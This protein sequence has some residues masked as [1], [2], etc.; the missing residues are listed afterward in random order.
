MRRQF[1]RWQQ[2][3]LHNLH[4]EW[5]RRDIAKAAGDT[6][7]WQWIDDVV[8]DSITDPSPT[9]MRDIADALAAGY[10]SSLHSTLKQIDL[11]DPNALL[12]RGHTEA[13]DYAASRGAE[14][15][16]KRYDT[17]GNLV[18]NPDADW[19]ITDTTRGVLRR[20][21]QLA[22]STHMDVDKLADHI[23]DTGVFSDDRAEMI[24]RTEMNMAQS[25]GVLEAGRQAA[26]EGL[27]VQ[28]VWTL[29]PNPCPLCEDAAAEG[30]I[31]LDD[32]FG[33]DAGDAPPL[34]PNCECSLDLFV[35]EE[36]EK[37]YDPSEP[38]DA[39]GR[40]TSGGGGGGE[41]ESPAEHYA[42]LGG[43]YPPHGAK[44]G[45]HDDGRFGVSR[46]AGSNVGKDVNLSLRRGHV[47]GEF[48]LDPEQE[49]IAK[50]LT[51]EINEAPR[52][53]EDV[54]VYRAAALPP[55]VLGQMVPGAIIEDKGFTSATLDPKVVEFHM[56]ETR[57]YAGQPVQLLEINLPKGSAAT[58][59]KGSTER[60][61][62]VQR[63]AKFKVGMATR[64]EGA[65][66][67]TWHLELMQ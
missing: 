59:V 33:S 25:Q 11:D 21:I 47:G 15:V 7:L 17:D 65:E 52:L 45:M 40:W 57:Q 61:I 55:E 3:L 49:T 18:D 51:K 39:H 34:H 12:L 41:A 5:A 56:D 16:G 6:P 19:V 9:S 63:G 2:Q 58:L 38:R 36:T 1:A 44:F 42:R 27:A 28:K 43:G 66:Y 31:D 67:P 46:Y 24:A 20:E 14:L 8:D 23:T 62:I 54:T 10:V 48:V 37:V 29:G 64:A 26:A 60:E 35:E 53:P 50:E 22:A 30:V 4:N 32:D 13:V